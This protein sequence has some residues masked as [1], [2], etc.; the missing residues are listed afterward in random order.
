MF[1]EQ[2]DF[3][4]ALEDYDHA[5]TLKPLDESIRNNR[6][7]LLGELNGKLEPGMKVVAKSPG[8]VLRD[9]P[10]VIPMPSPLEVY[11]VQAVD[12]DRV[13]LCCGSREGDALASELIR[14]GQAE[15]YFSDQIKA[16]PGAATAPDESRGPI[17]SAR[18]GQC[19][20]RLRPGDSPR[21]QEP[22][23]PHRAEQPW[24]TRAT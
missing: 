23:G 15:S 20:L 2:Q 21:A 4:K 5:L 19:A 8:F 17:A 7:R 18:P 11:Q 1:W 3:G 12:G 14:A 24:P 6:A 16:N 9:G 22:L 13:R 10:K